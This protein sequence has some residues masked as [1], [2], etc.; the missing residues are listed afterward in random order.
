MWLLCI[1]LTNDYSEAD[2][3]FINVLKSGRE[4]GILHNKEILYL[5]ERT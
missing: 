2:F 1:F 3:F 4:S 5:S